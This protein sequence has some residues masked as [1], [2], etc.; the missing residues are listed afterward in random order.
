MRFVVDTSALVAIR[1]GE[2]EREVFHRIL[3]EG[4]PILSV[5][6]LTELTMV[7]QARYG[8]ADLGNLDQMTALYRIEIEPVE[9]EDAALLRHAIIAFGRGRATEP[10]VLN[11]G[12]L[13]SYALARRLGLPLLFKG[14]DF[15]L[16]DVASALDLSSR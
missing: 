9:A 14:G 12:D 3:L 4:E 7:W 1:A 13:F 8:A 5:A 2:P 16:T 15:G 11:F 10:A 6:S